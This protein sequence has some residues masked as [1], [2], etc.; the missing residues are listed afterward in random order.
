MLQNEEFPEILPR[1]HLLLPS[2]LCGIK[3]SALRL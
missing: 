3:Q 1:I 2:E